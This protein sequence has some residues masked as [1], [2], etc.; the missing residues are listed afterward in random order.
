MTTYSSEQKHDNY[1]RI[2][3]T[4]K[5]LEE[6]QCITEDW[7]ESNKARIEPN[8]C[9]DHSPSPH[10]EQSCSLQAVAAIAAGPARDSNL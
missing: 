10:L 4:I 3:T 5:F 2:L 1:L 6:N 9:D 7:M 8:R